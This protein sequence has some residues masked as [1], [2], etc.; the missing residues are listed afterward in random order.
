MGNICC[1]LL[2]NLL[3]LL[4]LSKKYIKIDMVKIKFCLFYEWMWNLLFQFKE[5]E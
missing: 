1:L 4:L 2:Q 3:F 5:I